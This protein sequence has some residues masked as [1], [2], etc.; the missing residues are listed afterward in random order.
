MSVFPCVQTQAGKVVQIELAPSATIDEDIVRVRVRA[1]TRA[2]VWESEFHGAF[3]PE[4]RST[5]T[6]LLS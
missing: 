5:V 6:G 2:M 4:S 3:Q 1:R